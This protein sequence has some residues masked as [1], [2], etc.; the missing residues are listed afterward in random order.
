[1]E[2]AELY[3]LVKTFRGYKYKIGDN[4]TSLSGGQRQRIG[5]ARSFYYETNINFDEATNA[6]DE[7]IER[8]INENIM[9]KKEQSNNY[10]FYNKDILKQC[11][12]IYEIKA[13]NTFKL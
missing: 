10:Y 8:S 12:E 6:L 5:L 4:G 3:N 1:M 13:I 7:K 9:Q 11:D 2:K